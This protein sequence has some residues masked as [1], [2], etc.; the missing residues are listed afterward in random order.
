MQIQLKAEAQLWNATGGKGF[1]VV[2]PKKLLG[3]R[4]L[5]LRLTE[6]SKAAESWFCIKHTRVCG[7]WRLESSCWSRAIMSQ[8]TILCN[9]SLRI[10]KLKWRTLQ[11]VGDG[12]T[13]R[14]LLRNTAGM[15]ERSR[16]VEGQGH[17]RPLSPRW[18]YH[19]PQMLQDLTFVFW[20]MNLTLVW[21]FLA[22][23]LFLPFGIVM[24]ILWHWILELSNLLFVLIR[25]L[26]RLS[27]V[28]EQ[29]WNFYRL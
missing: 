18:F 5:H 1:T 9:E 11:D 21:S 28:L 13:M 22:M 4:F 26:N 23:Y 6:E 3:L 25:T 12:R 27:W 20:D 14:C 10:S 29:G 2:S 8:G 17:T 7:L 16:Y 15:E 19:K 24:L